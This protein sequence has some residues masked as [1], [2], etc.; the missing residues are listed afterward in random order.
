LLGTIFDSHVKRFDKAP[1]FRGEQKYEPAGDTADLGS[2]HVPDVCDPYTRTMR[3]STGPAA[4]PPDQPQ[5]CGT[6]ASTLRLRTFQ[7]VRSG[8]EGGHDRVAAEAAEP[9]LAHR[10]AFGKRA[11]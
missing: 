8:S 1:A 5:N 7:L 9:V 4:S 10:R 11:A 6:L 2:I 3:E